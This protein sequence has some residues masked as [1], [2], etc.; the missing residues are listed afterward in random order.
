MDENIYPDTDEL[1]CTEQKNETESKKSYISIIKNLN[2]NQMGTQNLKYK[3]YNLL[4]L[5]LNN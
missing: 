1:N 4:Y 3:L 5:F 2:E